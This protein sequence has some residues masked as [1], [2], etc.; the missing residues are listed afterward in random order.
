MWALPMGM[1]VE[2][3]WLAMSGPPSVCDTNVRV[4]DLSQVWLTL[5]DKLFQLDHFP[6]FFEG[7][8]LVFFVS[9]YSQA[10]RVIPSI[11]QS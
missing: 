5:R 1:T 6:N 9:I 2:T 7:K 3:R 8:D 10:C 4:K 11:F